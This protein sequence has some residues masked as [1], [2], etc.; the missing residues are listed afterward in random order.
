MATVSHWRERSRQAIE[1]ALKDLPSD[2]DLPTIKQALREAY[3]FG[4]RRGHPYK[5]WCAEQRIALAHLTPKL[6][7]RYGPGDAPYR[8]TRKSGR[9]LWLIVCCAFCEEQIAGGCMI[10]VK[11]QRRLVEV[12]ADPTFLSL[13]W[14]ASDDNKADKAVFGDYLEE[15]LGTRCGL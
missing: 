4:L 5:M 9:L 8:L 10:C 1:A 2:A 13:R 3:P 14:A 6:P 15:N 12:T 11:R 7:H